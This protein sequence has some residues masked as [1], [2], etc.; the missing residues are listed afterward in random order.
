MSMMVDAWLVG[1]LLLGDEIYG[2]MLWID[3]GHSAQQNGVSFG[4]EL[5]GQN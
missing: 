5:G 3:L 4:L 1:L 2:C